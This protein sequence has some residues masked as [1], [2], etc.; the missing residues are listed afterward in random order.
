MDFRLYAIQQPTLIV[1][2]K[3]DELIPLSSGEKI[4]RSI[5]GSSLLVVD[6]CGHLTPAECSR[7]SLQGM[8]AFLGAQPPLRGVV[9]TVNGGQ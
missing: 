4:Y 9:R 6:G 7:V 2:G 5:H 1:W 8:V 3:Q